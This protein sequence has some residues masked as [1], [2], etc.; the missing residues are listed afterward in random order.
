VTEA[1][2]YCNKCGWLGKGVVV[3]GG[4]VHPACSYYAAPMGQTSRGSSVVRGAQLTLSRRIVVWA[5]L[6]LAWI[7]DK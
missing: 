5:R 3:N 7:L 2:G 1:M 4:I 6:V